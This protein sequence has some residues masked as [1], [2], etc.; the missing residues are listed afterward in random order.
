MADTVTLSVNDTA[1]DV[2]AD[3]SLAVGRYNLQNMSRSQCI[4]IHFGGDTAP[5]DNTIYHEI[6]PMYVDGQNWIG[7]NIETGDNVWVR[8]RHGTATVAVTGE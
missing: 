6:T 4:L 5:T 8:T 1:K 2:V 7:L 3:L